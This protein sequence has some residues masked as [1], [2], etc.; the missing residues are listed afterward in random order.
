MLNLS[1]IIDFGEK[2]CD[3]K[4][5]MI[6]MAGRRKTVNDY[7]GASNLAELNYWLS[8]HLMIRRM[9]KDVLKEL[10]P[11]NR[12]KMAVEISGKEK[13]Q[14]EKLMKESDEF[15]SKVEKDQGKKLEVHEVLRMIN[16]GEIDTEDYGVKSANPASELYQLTGIAKVEGGFKFMENLLENGIKFLIF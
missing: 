12:I 6:F 9:K 4:V 2:Y 16:T 8:K 5:K 14:L 3:A 1:Y 13:K 15:R 11:K 7:N 10:P